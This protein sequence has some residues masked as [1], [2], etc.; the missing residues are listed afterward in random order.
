MF[1]IWLL[2]YSTIT[3]AHRNLYFLGF[4]GFL[5]Y[6]FLLIKCVDFVLCNNNKLHIIKNVAFYAICNTILTAVCAFSFQIRFTYICKVE[7]NI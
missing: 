5:T 6:D 7:S 4:L 2:S 1:H 3:Y